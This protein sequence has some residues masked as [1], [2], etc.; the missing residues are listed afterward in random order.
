MKYAAL[1]QKIFV[2]H[3]SLQSSCGISVQIDKPKLTQFVTSSSSSFRNKIRS[4]F[5]LTS[6]FRP[7]S[8]PPTTTQQTTLN[9]LLS[10]SLK[11]FIKSYKWI[12]HK[13]ILKHKEKYF[14]CRI[15]F[16]ICMSDV[17]KMNKYDLDQCICSVICADVA[18]KSHHLVS[19]ELALTSLNN[20]ET[21]NENEPEDP[22]GLVL[23]QVISPWTKEEEVRHLKK[24]KRD[25]SIELKNQCH[26]LLCQ[27]GN[28]L[29]KD[30]Y[31]GSHWGIIKKQTEITPVEEC[32][33]INIDI[34]GE[35]YNGLCL[36]SDVSS[37]ASAQINEIN[38]EIKIDKK[39]YTVALLKP[40]DYI[41]TDLLV[42]KTGFFTYGMLSSVCI[43]DLLAA[44]NDYE[45]F[46]TYNRKNIDNNILEDEEQDDLRYTQNNQK[47]TDYAM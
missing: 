15:C 13:K 5:S 42:Y 14:V 33:A 18:I 23:Y 34:F 26:G 45:L 4:T 8:P 28:P 44:D 7:T 3:P 2:E 47:D 43:K 6:A 36:I 31:I 22:K 11:L 39:K 16:H 21:P 38:G 20:N 46:T 1:V 40:R 10:P 27:R 32:Y 41:N 37:S 25:L 12:T 29:S 24:I 9:Q 30:E 17:A 19:L 35:D